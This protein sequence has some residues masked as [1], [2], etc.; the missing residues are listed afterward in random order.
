MIRILAIMDLDLAR[1]LKLNAQM[2]MDQN[3]IA[4]NLNHLDKEMT[5]YLDQALYLKQLDKDMQITMDLDRDLKPNA[6]TI[7][8]QNTIAH[9]LNHLTMDPDLALKP[10]AKTTMD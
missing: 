9:N 10:N 3:T 8:D 5:M 1:A 6:K 2:T 4:H 7:T